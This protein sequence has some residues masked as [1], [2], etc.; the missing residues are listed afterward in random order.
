MRVVREADWLTDLTIVS[1][2]LCSV[3]SRKTITFIPRLAWK[4]QMNAS[5]LGA[6]IAAGTGDVLTYSVA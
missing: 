1:S 5:V 2:S 4:S 6:Q 3:G